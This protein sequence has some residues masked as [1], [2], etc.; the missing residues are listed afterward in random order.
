MISTDE[1]PGAMRYVWP[2]AE[3]TGQD[4][5]EMV[6]ALKVMESV[7]LSDREAG[8]GLRAVLAR[9]SQPM[10]RA[11][12]AFGLTAQD[13][14][15]PNGLKPLGEIVALLEDGWKP[16][17]AWLRELALHRLVGLDGA[18]AL[19]VLMSCGARRDATPL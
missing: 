16:R 4:T 10:P 11:L 19:E 15:G 18:L 12:G 5:C 14:Q 3:A 8:R 6:A 7:G 9:L 17:R 1:Q 13:L 2:I